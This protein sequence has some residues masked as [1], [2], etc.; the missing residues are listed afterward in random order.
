MDMLEENNIHEQLEASIRN[1]I[2]NQQDQKK[3]DI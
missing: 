3:N 1:K 2:S